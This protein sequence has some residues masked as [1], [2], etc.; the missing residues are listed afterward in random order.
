MDKQ[1][2]N[3]LLKFGRHVKKLRTE[4]KLSQDE[5]VMNSDRLIKATVSD[6]ENGK[7]NLSFTTL[8]DLAKGLGRNP[9]ELLDFEMKLDKE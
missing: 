6:I 7:R 5:V 8:I 3:I 9:K 1:K 4:S 2:E